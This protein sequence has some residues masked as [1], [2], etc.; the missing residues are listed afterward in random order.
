[1]DK[2]LY[3]TPEAELTA[4]SQG[5]ADTLLKIAGRQRAMLTAF[6]TLVA[7]NSLARNF[8]PEQYQLAGTVLSLACLAALAITVVRLSNLMNHIAITVLLGITSIIPLINLITLLTLIRQSTRR[9]KAHGIRV[10]LFG[11]KDEDIRS[12][13]ESVAQEGVATHYA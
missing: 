9:L 2:E 3:K 4:M 5:D 1:M 11:A 8:M 6:A 13:V 7:V 10:G 12:R